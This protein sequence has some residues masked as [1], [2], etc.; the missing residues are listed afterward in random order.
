ML[1]TVTIWRDKKK[2]DNGLTA[3]FAKATQ[4]KAAED[5][6]YNGKDGTVEVK[7]RK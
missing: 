7:R 2:A 4:V 1:S 6:K 3:R 5:L